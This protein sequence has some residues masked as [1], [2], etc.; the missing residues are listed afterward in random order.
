MSDDVEEISGEFDRYNRMS[1]SVPGAGPR[2]CEANFVPNVPGRWS[3][4]PFLFRAKARTN[5]EPQ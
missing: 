5:L 1:R 2:A 3:F 4:L